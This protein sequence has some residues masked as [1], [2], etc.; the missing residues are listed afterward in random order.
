MYTFNIYTYLIHKSIGVPGLSPEVVQI[1][2]NLVSE[3]S[4]SVPSELIR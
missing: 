3:S 1:D 4:E 2:V